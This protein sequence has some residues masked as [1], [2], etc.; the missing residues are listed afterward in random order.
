LD[1]NLD[2]VVARGEEVLTSFVTRVWVMQVYKLL[3]SF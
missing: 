1:L 3:K 2:V